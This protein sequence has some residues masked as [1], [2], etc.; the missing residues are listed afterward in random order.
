MRYLVIVFVIFVSGLLC[1]PDVKALSVSVTAN[2]SAENTWTDSITAKRKVGFL[3]I[4][5]SGTWAGTVTLQRSFDG[6]GTWHDVF[7]WTANAQKALTDVE[8]GVLYR[9]GIDTGDYTSGTAAVRLSR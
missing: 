3:N 4:S 2:I 7:T 1:A 8:K 9:I 6:G 5:V